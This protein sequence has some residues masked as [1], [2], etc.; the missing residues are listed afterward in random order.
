MALIQRCSI[1]ENV[2]SVSESLGA[3]A[4]RGKLPLKLT[5]RHG[6][7]LACEI[8]YELT[9]GGDDRPPII[10]AGGISAGRHVISS[11]A[12]PEHGW[13]EVQKPALSSDRRVLAINWIGADGLIDAPIDPADQAEALIQ[14]LTVL[15]IQRA[16]AFVG[17]SYGAM[18]GMHLAA[19]HPQRIGALLAISASARPHP[20]ASACRSLQRQA[21]SLGESGSDAA[22]GVALARAMA[23]LT[24]RTPEEFAER[25][26]AAPL[27]ERD[28]VRV[29]A[30]GYL[31]AHGSR[32]CQRMSSVAYR[33]LSESIDL[34]R[35]NPAE[36][37]IPL[38]LAAVDRDALVPAADVEALAHAVPGARFHLLK[39]LFG[40]DAFL[41]EEEQ[42]GNV[43]T[44]FLSS[45]EHAE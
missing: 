42:V 43:I 37:R 34:H 32:H 30:E 24:Y 17:A 23:M 16:A 35:I 14:V 38:T 25:F 28:R 22:A 2:S 36:I 6:A 18:V 33:R 8:S 12:Y 41:K 20:F 29:A 9:S 31:N 5:L 26:D 4:L 39:S 19:K 3:R 21:L 1:A 40:H 7:A 11:E 15:G 44:Q 13:W 27:I 10:V 45:L